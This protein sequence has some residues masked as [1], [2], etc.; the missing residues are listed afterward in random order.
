MLQSIMLNTIMHSLQRLEKFP[1]SGVTLLE[2]SLN[3]FNFRMVIIDPYIAF[4]R[5]IDNIIFIYRILHGA[6][7]YRHLLKDSVK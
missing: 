5:F 3:K 2:R 4:Y 6:R 1:H 7:D